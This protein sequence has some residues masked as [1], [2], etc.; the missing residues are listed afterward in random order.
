MRYKATSHTT[1][2]RFS[3]V[4]QVA[5]T[6]TSS[7][8]S[9]LALTRVHIPNDI[10]IASTVSRAHDRDRPTDSRQTDRPTALYS[11]CKNRPHLHSTATRPN[12]NNNNQTAHGRAHTSTTPKLCVVCLTLC[13]NHTLLYCLIVLL[14]YTIIVLVQVLLWFCLFLYVLCNN[15]NNNNNNNVDKVA[16]HSS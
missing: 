16:G 10:S 2:R 6:C 9:F 12:N 5:P 8:T 15:N 1:S 13:N 7:N 3:R 4:R 11:A 14:Y